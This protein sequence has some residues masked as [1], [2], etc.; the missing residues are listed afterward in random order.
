[1][2]TPMQPPPFPVK[3]PA[4]VCPPTPDI[5]EILA[6][7]DMQRYYT[8]TPVHSKD[9]TIKTRTSDRPPMP[10]EYTVDGIQIQVNIEK[11]IFLKNLRPR[12]GP[13]HKAQ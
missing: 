9:M 12:K 7:E 1:M 8:R 10:N 13:N 5:K 11:V 6:E 4:D 2:P 3:L